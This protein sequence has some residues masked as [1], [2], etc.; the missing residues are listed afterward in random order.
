MMR[1]VIISIFALL[2][3]NKFLS[4]NKSYERTIDMFPKTP[5]AAALSKFIDIPPGN[6]TGV[7]NFS[8]PLY[9]IDLDGISIPIELNYVTN[10]IKVGELA[11]RVGL[12]WSLNTGA[13]LSQ[14]VIGARDVTSRSHILIDWNFNPIISYPACTISGDYYKA[15]AVTSY[16]EAEPQIDLKPD[17]FAYSL[18]NGKSGKFI[19]DAQNETGV[20]MPYNSIKIKKGNVMDMMI[21][22]ETGIRYDFSHIDGSI[23]TRNTCYREDNNLIFPFDP[24]YHLTK[25]STQKNNFINYHYGMPGGVEIFYV[26]SVSTQKRIAVYKPHNVIA[27]PPSI[28]RE[29]CVNY[30]RSTDKPIS[31]IIFPGGKIL[32]T[33][34]NKNE[35]PRLDIKGDVFLKGMTVQD[36][37][38]N[39][40]KD[41]TFNYDY[42]ESP[43][44]IPTILEEDYS[45]PDYFYNSSYLFGVDK[46]LKL[47]SVRDNLNN[48]EYKLEYYETYYDQATQ[49]EKTLPNRISNDVDFWG[50]YNG[51]ENGVKSI[52]NSIY[53]PPTNISSSYF[54]ADKNPD[55]NYG[56][57]GNLR[58]ITYPTGGY[59]EIKYEADE[60]DLS[61]PEI[62][63][64]YAEEF[65]P[66]EADNLANPLIEMP[67]TITDNSSNQQILFTTTYSSP[68]N[69]NGHC[70]WKL[71]KP[72]NTTEEGD[73]VGSTERNDSPGNYVLSVTKDMDN[74]NV[75]CKAKYS[76]TDVTK[77]PID[78]L[79]TRKAGTLRIKQIEYVDNNGGKIE[80][81]YTYK[82]P[83]A[84]HILPYTKN[85]GKNLG[86]ELFVS[87]FTKRMPNNVLPHS[88]G[89]STITEFW[90]SNNPGWQT[91]TV[92]GKSVGYDYVQEYY[93]D[94]KNPQ[95]SYRKEFKFQNDNYGTSYEASSAINVTWPGGGYDR[96]LVLEE[97]LFNSTNELIKRTE[98]LYDKDYSFNN[99]YSPTN[100]V[101]ENIMGVGLEIIPITSETTD[102]SVL[103]PM[104]IVKF[105]YNPFGLENYWIK[106]VK[107]TTTDYV[108]SQPTVVTEQTTAY[109]NP[110]QH[111]F[112]ES[113]TTSVVGSGVNTSQHYKYAHDLNNYLKEKNIIG[114][115]LETE[116]KKEGVTISK[117]LTNY[118]ATEAEAKQR[119]VNN[120][121]NKD[122]PLPF[123][124]LSKDIE[125]TGGMN[126]E[127][128]YNYYDSKGNILQYTLKPAAN[129]NGIPVAIIW[130][131]NQ[132]QP[133]AKIEGVLYDNIKT[134]SLVTAII[135]ASD[136]D[137]V[138]LPNN[139]ETNLLTALDNLRKSN[140]F[141]DYQ[142]TTYTYDPLIGVRSI[143][144]P[145]GIR[146]YYIYDTANRLEK[147]T[148]INGNI[149]KEYKY[150][151]KH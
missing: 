26:S 135:S 82:E 18:L 25:I 22:D 137:A 132:S 42:F 133:I 7:A 122:F 70:V 20:P 83:T 51:K 117:T 52:S 90:A 39:I 6:Y 147:V 55:I 111:I 85:S 136:T 56:R 64:D 131:Y 150:N 120:I 66:V 127:V 3:V 1:K 140:D 31:E 61:E 106:S 58:K 24:N 119:I 63:Y 62:V 46:R 79:Y 142:I 53:A 33:Y 101:S 21:T 76:W 149:L 102:C 92:R 94:S 9:T 50:V 116:V 130:G 84:N 148:D 107:T 80:R 77:T 134:H 91:T 15:L 74:P 11:S 32:F 121:E 71:K 30:T 67:F 95:N 144:P 10:G 115:P 88:M 138:Q 65:I 44:E 125:P 13:S 29:K 98:N 72:D 41:Y 105:E 59:T 2:M 40:I 128:E 73:T 145:S 12:G 97:Q 143:T 104:S 114:I 87:R 123:S 45:Y 54:G 17:I 124:V 49:I 100:S 8:I 109:T 38:N 141:K 69:T 89:E 23:K 112:P 68:Y 36:N 35:E 57:L 16:L 75:T 110:P 78:T 37:A 48:N 28:I 86:E 60:F 4:Q 34:N 99:K 5:D 47:V 96:G 14:Q 129:G 118:P 81:Q 43:G 151:Y 126:K 146:E 27:P 113:Q 93:V 103:G 139:D 108:N 19:L